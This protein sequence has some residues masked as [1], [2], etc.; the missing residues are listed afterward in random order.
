[1]QK[2]KKTTQLAA[3]A[4]EKRQLSIS[5]DELLS[6]AE[7][8]KLAKSIG[9]AD[10]FRASG[11]GQELLLK[12]YRQR[13]WLMRLLLGKRCLANEYSAL[14]YIQSHALARVPRPLGWLDENSYAI[15]YIPNLGHVENPEH[16]P[17]KTQ[18]RS[19]FE[20][21]VSM[22]LVLHEHGIAHGDLRRANILVG[23][24]GHPW[25]IDFAT[26]VNL[27]TSRLLLRKLY[28]R[29][30]RVMDLH[31]LG[32]ILQMTYPELVQGEIRECLEHPPWFVRLGHFYRHGIYRNVVRR[33]GSRSSD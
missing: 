30:F 23:K 3:N 26:S 31:S 22:V 9:D 24:D 18:S 5:L 19:F 1:M 32:K 4:P 29:M 2:T 10:V 15:E 17:E 6:H 14:D 28:F 21:L 25:L 11:E 12:T 8:L 7:P 27:N 20:E 33:K 13:P 16:H